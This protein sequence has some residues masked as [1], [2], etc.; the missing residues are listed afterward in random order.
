MFLVNEVPPHSRISLKQY[1]EM[2]RHGILTEDN[3]VELWEGR[4]VEKMPKRRP[5]T[6]R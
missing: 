6:W 2:V 3:P 5:S 4:L 1:H